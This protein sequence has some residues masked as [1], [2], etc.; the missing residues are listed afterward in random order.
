MHDIR[1]PLNNILFATKETPAAQQISESVHRALQIADNF[2]DV[3]R[4]AEGAIVVRPTYESIYQT[5][6]CATA[7]VKY[8]MQEKNNTIQLNIANSLSLNFDKPL[9]ERV[10]VNILTNSIKHA[11]PNS[12]IVFNC[13]FLEDCVRFEIK[14]NGN[15]IHP[16]DIHSVFDKFYSKEE[17]AE[18]AYKSKGLG[19]WFCKMAIDAHG[20]TIGL[21][22]SYPKNGTS[23]WFTLPHLTTFRADMPVDKEII[24]LNIPLADQE[25]ALIKRHAARLCQCEMYE[26]GSIVKILNNIVV[27]N[28]PNVELWKDMLTNAVVK[29]N[30]VFFDELMTLLD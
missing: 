9:I 14:N 11:L 6:L 26:T 20:G 15:P 19:L 23:T 3:H 5:A 27:P 4:M 22:S 17:I 30:K 28:S 24:D 29:N 21:A 12:L 25:K 16:N 1:N 8:M 13:E 18:T 2:M 10:F 7:Q